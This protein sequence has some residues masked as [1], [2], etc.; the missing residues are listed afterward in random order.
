MKLD[1]LKAKSPVFIDANIFIYHFT[2]ASDESS[3]FL[4]QCESGVYAGITSAT[5]ILEVLHRLMM[6][7]AVHKRLIHPPNLVT[8]LKKHPE[9]IK[10][11]HDYFTNTQKIEQMGITIKPVSAMTILKSQIHRSRYG[12]MVNDSIIVTIMEEEGIS[13]LATHDKDFIS[14]ADIKVFSPQ[15][16]D[17]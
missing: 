5:V 14:V 3:F 11:L 1:S 13:F 7:E 17:L 16:I 6:V 12:L 15:D 4:S 8:K 2:G 9:K 10:Q